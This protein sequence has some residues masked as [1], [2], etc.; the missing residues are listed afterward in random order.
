MTSSQRSFG[1]R[2]EA[3][4]F[5]MLQVSVV[6]KGDKEHNKIMSLVFSSIFTSTD[7][8]SPTNSS[9]VLMCCIRS[10]VSYIFSPCNLCLRYSMVDTDVDLDIAFTSESE[11]IHE[12][13][14]KL[15]E[16]TNLGFSFYELCEFIKYK[17]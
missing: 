1:K 15:R 10:E 16:N 7:T 9:N 17:L 3:A 5:T 11:N 6:N 2:N 12:L 8:C 13:V 4:T 14:T